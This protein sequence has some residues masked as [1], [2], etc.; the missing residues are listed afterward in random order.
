[1]ALN[2]KERNSYFFAVCAQHWLPHTG[3]EFC[4]Q[5]IN[6][7][8]AQPLMQRKSCIMQPRSPSLAH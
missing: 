7:V 8:G 5:T 4:W 1:M 3:F 6:L 2:N